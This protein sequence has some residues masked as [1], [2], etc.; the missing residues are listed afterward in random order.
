MKSSLRFSKASRSTIRRVELVVRRGWH[1]G[2]QPAD[3]YRGSARSRREAGL[4]AN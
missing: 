2:L 3:F 4:R 1:P